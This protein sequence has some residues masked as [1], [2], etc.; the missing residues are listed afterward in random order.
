MLPSVNRAVPRAPRTL[1]HENLWGIH[2][3]L[4]PGRVAGIGEMPKL[5]CFVLYDSARLEKPGRKQLAGSFP[6]GHFSGVSGAALSPP[7]RWPLWRV[8]FFL[9]KAPVQRGRCRA[10]QRAVYSL[11]SSSKTEDLLDLDKNFSDRARRRSA[12]RRSFICNQAQL[13]LRG[14]TFEVYTRRQEELRALDAVCSVNSYVGARNVD[15]PENFVG[16]QP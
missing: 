10:V 13:N 9:S 12:A 16:T 1:M 2:G 4:A 8:C 11:T 5:R 15:D 7:C 3:G 14:L 6:T